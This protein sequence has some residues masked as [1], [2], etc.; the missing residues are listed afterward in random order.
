MSF[1][2]YQ[3]S[4]F[5]PIQNF[6][7]N[8]NFIHYVAPKVKFRVQKNLQGSRV[9]VTRAKMDSVGNSVLLRCTP[10]TRLHVTATVCSSCKHIRG[11]RGALAWVSVYEA[12]VLHYVLSS[13]TWHCFTSHMLR[14]RVAYATEQ[15]ACAV[16][17]RISEV[18]SH[19]FLTTYS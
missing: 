5:I 11:F 15:T 19:W 8:Y 13:A 4:N 2:Q 10:E 6:R 16:F 18:F 9:T 17:E 1:R 12:A 7:Q 14:V 3:K